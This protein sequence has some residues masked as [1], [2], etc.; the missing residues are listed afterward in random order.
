M[1]T[2]F[3]HTGIDEQTPSI[4]M[5]ESQNGNEKIVSIRQGKPYRQSQKSL[6]GRI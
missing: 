3:N 1:A 2:G 6:P 5:D 4:V